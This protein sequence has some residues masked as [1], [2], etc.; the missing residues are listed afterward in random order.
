MN[1][2]LLVSRGLG[3]FPYKSNKYEKLENQMVTAEPDIRQINRKDIDYIF[4]GCDGLWESKSCKEM[5]NWLDDKL[6]TN[7]M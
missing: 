6:K 7:S 3:D 2:D 4:L 5:K 1:G